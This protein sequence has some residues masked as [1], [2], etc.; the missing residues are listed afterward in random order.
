[1]RRVAPQSHKVSK[2]FSLNVELSS[3]L[4]EYFMYADPSSSNR[5]KR[6]FIN[7]L[8]QLSRMLFGAAM[9][10]DVEDLRERFFF[11]LHKRKQLK[12]TQKKT[13]TKKARHLLLLIEKKVSVY[14]V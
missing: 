2:E 4:N 12:G 3:A 13:K 11:F 6:G 7:E 10:E 5:T 8:W 1:M 9:N 14:N